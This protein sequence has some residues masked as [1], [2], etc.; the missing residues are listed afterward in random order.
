M[1]VTVYMG[2]YHLSCLGY[3]ELLN[4]LLDFPCPRIGALEEAVE[5]RPTA[6]H[7]T[8]RQPITILAPNRTLF[9]AHIP[10]CSQPTLVM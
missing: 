5:T 1:Y 10:R 3:Y 7:F 2:Y 8:A 4:L 6:C 9:W